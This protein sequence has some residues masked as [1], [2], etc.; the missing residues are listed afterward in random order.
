MLYEP[1]LVAALVVAY[2]HVDL[3]GVPLSGT[4]Q[5][6]HTGLLGLGTV[7]SVPASVFSWL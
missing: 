1:V 2:G 6:A 7:T 4:P 3:C 5:Y